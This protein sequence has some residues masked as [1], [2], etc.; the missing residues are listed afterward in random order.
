MVE[1]FLK[2]AHLESWNSAPA[3]LQHGQSMS[4]YRQQ[5]PTWN[6][7]SIPRNSWK[8]FI[9]LDILSYHG[10]H[11]PKSNEQMKSVDVNVLHFLI[12]RH[13]LEAAFTGTIKIFKDPLVPK[14]SQLKKHSSTR[15]GPP[16]D[17]N[18]TTA[19]RASGISGLHGCGF[20]GLAD[21]VCWCSW[22][23]DHTRRNSHQMSSTF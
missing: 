20:L 1:D 13:Q 23:A 14:V 11:S 10:I 5:L 18:G 22:K 2:F 12:S 4:Q 21:L 8:F 3:G 6:L 17:A 19:I 16:K 9:V 7:A 15:I